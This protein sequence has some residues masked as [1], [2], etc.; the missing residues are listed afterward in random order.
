MGCR[1]FCSVCLCSFYFASLWLAVLPLLVGAQ[2]WSVVV[3]LVL[4]VLLHALLLF[5]TCV[6]L[7]PLCMLLVFGLN[8][9]YL[10]FPC[11]YVPYVL[12]AL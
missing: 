3:S 8:F 7:F 10:W 11:S 9:L 6:P 4:F 2:L 1:Q 5:S 12:F